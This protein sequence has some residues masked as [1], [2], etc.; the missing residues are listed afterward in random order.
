MVQ[1]FDTPAGL[2]CLDELEAN[3]CWKGNLDASCKIVLVRGD[4]IIK[5]VIPFGN[6][7]PGYDEN[8][9]KFHVLYNN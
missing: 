9:C 1:K 3:I 2:A 6:A 7:S 5:E 8:A 4:M